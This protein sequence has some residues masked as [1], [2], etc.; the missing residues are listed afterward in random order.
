MGGL[1]P[2]TMLDLNKDEVA[3]INHEEN[4]LTSASMVSVDD[5]RNK[6]R[7]QK[8]CIPTKV[9]EFMLTLKKYVNLIYAVFS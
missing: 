2:F 6:Q 7:K 9:D 1:S 4:L 8:I 5:P 3:C